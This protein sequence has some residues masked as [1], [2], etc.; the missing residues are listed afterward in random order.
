MT[1]INPHS[2][3]QRL[4]QTK[5]SIDSTLNHCNRND[6]VLLL[7]VS[8]TQ[9]A[10][11]VRQA[12]QCG[13]RAFGEN[14]VQEG[15]E[16]VRQLQDLDDIEWHFIGPIQ[17]NKTRPVTENFAWVHSVDRIKIAQRLSEQRPDHLPKLNICL[18]VNID[19]QPTKSGFR[20]E[21]VTAAVEEIL[22]LPNVT[23]RGL[24]AIPAP[25]DSEEQ[26]R[27]PLRALK[28]L[29]TALQKQYPEQDYPN[30]KLDTLSMGMSDDMK[31]AIMEG[32]T[33]VRVGT[34]I[35]GSRNPTHS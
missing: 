2:I 8:K 21:E 33:I 6:S 17:S 31:A 16:K 10:T 15:V 27:A 5:D 29:L 30:L 34:A 20:P 7:A 3:E 11:K 1:S 25:H 4:Q 28:Q 18:Q 13:Q 35:F 9:P 32:S 23:L 14:Y 12:W 19:N 26:Q 24:M 22:K